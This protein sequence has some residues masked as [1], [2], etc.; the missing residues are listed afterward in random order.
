MTMS[1]H[2][3]EGYGDGDE[4]KRIECKD[5]ASTMTIKKGSE[6]FAAYS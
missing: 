6:V 2:V 1:F 3:N 4:G 5:E